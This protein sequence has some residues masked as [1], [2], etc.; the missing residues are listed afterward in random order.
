M[1]N[2]GAIK[3]FFGGMKT[4]V[5][6]QLK[7]SLSFSFKADKKGALTKLLFA[8]LGVAALTAVFVIVLKLLAMIGVLGSGGY[9]PMPMWNVVFFTLLLLNF[10]ACL[11]KTTDSLYFS[12]DNP[13]L[14]TYPVPS[15]HVYFSKLIVFYVGE[16][17]RSAFSLLPWLLSFGIANGMPIVFYPWTLFVI[18]ILSLIPVALSSVLSIPFLYVKTLIK[19]KPLIR[20][21][22]ILAVLIAATVFL[23]VITGNVPADLQIAAKWSTVYFPAINE[24]CRSFQRVLYPLIFLSHLAVGYTGTGADNPALMTVFTSSTAY[25]SLSVIGIVAALFVLAYFITKPLYFRM[26]SKSFEFD[27]PNIRHEFHRPLNELDSLPHS[28]IAAKEANAYGFERLCSLAEAIGTM[29]LDHQNPEAICAALNEL[30]R[31]DAFVLTDTLP[32]GPFFGFREEYGSF[33]LTAIERESKKIRCYCLAHTGK[34]NR[35]KPGFLSFLWREI[36]NDTRSGDALIGNYLL[37]V[38]PSVATLILNVI[39]EAMKKSFAG[40]RYTILF[41]A[42]VITLILLATNVSLASIFSREGKTA[43][44]LRANPTSFGFALGS[45]LFLRFALM[46]GSVIGAIVVYANHCSME[47]VRMDLLFFGV[48][49]LFLGHLLWSAEMDYMNPQVNLYSEVGSTTINPN[50]AKSA[51]L[52]F[53]LSAAFTGL[54]FLFTSQSPIYAYGHLLVACALFFL[55]RLVLFVQKVRAYGT[56]T[57]EGRGDR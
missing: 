18:L 47:Y 49:F 38:T 56:S 45:K 22:L 29:H 14:L 41:N 26:A 39:F 40:Q 2:K 25:I 10:F 37:L 8:V 53:I 57:Y 15:N 17:V 55:A 21:L 23:F 28:Y 5:V 6:M 31:G 54:L 33:R 30:C 32:E 48:Y 36:V 44:L 9:L 51:V 3:N 16:L 12:A 34:K 11:N 46:T 4:L 24:F 52:A 27:K 19:K 7:E 43:Y 42:L 13:V 1:A 35:V 20:S 50:E